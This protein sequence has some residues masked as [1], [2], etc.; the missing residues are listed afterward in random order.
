[1]GDRPFIAGSATDTDAESTYDEGSDEGSTTSDNGAWS[2]ASTEQV[3]AEWDEEEPEED[4]PTTSSDAEEEQEDED[5]ED[6]QGQLDWMARTVHLHAPSR[7]FVLASVPEDPFQS[8]PRPAWLCSSHSTSLTPASRIGRELG[9]AHGAQ[10][11]QLLAPAGGRVRHQTI[12]GEQPRIL[13]CHTCCKCKIPRG[14]GANTCSVGVE[15]SDNSFGWPSTDWR[16]CCCYWDYVGTK[17]DFGRDNFNQ[18]ACCPCKI[19]RETLEEGRDSERS[20]S[21]SA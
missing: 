3:T 16:C 21:R 9:E 11:L 12:N 10:E 1:M 5:E 15:L 14:H 13:S 19:R 4:A 6:Y 17:G 18:H 2:A 7:S 8:R 20:P